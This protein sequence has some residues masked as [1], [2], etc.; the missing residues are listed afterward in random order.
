ML[1]GADSGERQPHC[2]VDDGAGGVADWVFIF[3]E[4]NLAS[5]QSRD[6]QIICVIQRPFYFTVFIDVGLIINVSY[7][8][9]YVGCYV[10][11]PIYLSGEM[12]II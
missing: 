1:N 11:R 3:I 9:K 2:C 4:V 8:A 5:K 7:V 12:H 10:N 6:F